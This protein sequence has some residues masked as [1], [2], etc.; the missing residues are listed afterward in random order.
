MITQF[1]SSLY[2][3]YETNEG[4]PLYSP[5]LMRDFVEEHA[6]GLYKIILNLI[7]KD[8]TSKERK[9]LQEQRTVAILHILAYFRSQ[10]TSQFNKDAGAFLHHHGASRSAINTRPVLGYSVAPRTLDRQKETKKRNYPNQL[11]EHLKYAVDEK[12]FIMLFID[13]FH[14]IHTVRLPGSDMKLSVATHMTSSL[15]DIHPSIKAPKMPRSIDAVHCSP[16]VSMNGIM[17]KCVGGISVG[18][19]LTIAEKMKEWQTSFFSS[20][21]GYRKLNGES[22]QSQ[23]HEFRVY[24][25]LAHEELCKLNSCQLVDE[26]EHPLKSM[27]N[28]RFALDHTIS[29]AGQPLL[30]CTKEYALPCPGDWPSWFYFKK[31]VAQQSNSYA[32]RHLIPQ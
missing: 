11:Q 23:L 26:F 31:L 5:A 10:K 4:P 12:G 16:Y 29:S 15:L 8:T 32:S 6:C 14:N 19:L 28:Y 20:V 27:E 30:N 9:Q 13:D 25:D 24:H 22:V 17:Q 3:Y 21:P 2:E 1:Q 18:N 7:I